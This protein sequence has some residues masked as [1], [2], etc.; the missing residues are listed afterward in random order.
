MGAE[1][2]VAHGIAAGAG[3]VARGSSPQASAKCSDGIP[4]ATFDRA[5]RFM[6]PIL[7]VTDQ[8]VGPVVREQRGRHLVAQRRRRLARSQA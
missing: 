3:R 5:D 7:A 4:R 8:P 2:V 6:N 1:R